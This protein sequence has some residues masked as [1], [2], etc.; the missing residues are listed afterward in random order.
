MIDELSSVTSDLSAFND[1][2][3]TDSAIN[4]IFRAD[5]ILYGCLYLNDI[6]N[7]MSRENNS[8]VIE[9]NI[10][11]DLAYLFCNSSIS[12]DRSMNYGSIL[13][14]TASGTASATLCFGN[15]YQTN[16]IGHILQSER[17]M[18]EDQVD[19]SAVDVLLCMDINVY[20]Q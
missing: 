7:I 9:T 13:I 19:S 12:A 16:L 18:V 8:Q 17:L 2:T 14:E 4:S 3:I 5:I 1:L 15:C 20:K 11:G 6:N 10:Y